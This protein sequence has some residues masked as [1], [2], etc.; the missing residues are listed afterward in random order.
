MVIQQEEHFSFQNWKQTQRNS[1]AMWIQNQSKR[2]G[3]QQPM[4]LES[5]FK[6]VNQARLCCLHHTSIPLHSLPSSSRLAVFLDLY[7]TL[8]LLSIK[9]KHDFLPG[10]EVLPYAFYNDSSVSPLVKTI[11]ASSLYHPLRTS[12]ACLSSTGLKSIY[13]NTFYDN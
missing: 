8:L 7:Y 2:T 3:N 4:P 12:E 10:S 11:P 1:E 13:K 6:S 5:I 9:L